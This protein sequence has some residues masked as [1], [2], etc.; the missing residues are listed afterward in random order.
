M[1]TFLI[2]YK[3]PRRIAISKRTGKKGQSRKYILREN[4]RRPKEICEMSYS[5]CLSSTL[6]KLGYVCHI[7]TLCRK[8]IKD[9]PSPSQLHYLC[10]MQ[11]I[12]NANGW[13]M[14]IF[15]QWIG[16]TFSVSALKMLERNAYKTWWILLC[17][18]TGGGGHFKGIL[19]SKHINVNL[20]SSFIWCSHSFQVTG[21]C[22]SVLHYTL[23]TSNIY[24]M[25]MF[26]LKC[27][28]HEQFLCKPCHIT[29]WLCFWICFISSIQFKLIFVCVCVHVQGRWD[30]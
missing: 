8:L 21:M 1:T 13:F 30:F 7:L 14:L 12:M 19:S 16:W 25:C 4:Q 22:D 10:R 27:M 2:E 23:T 15:W 20:C 28:P 24:C 9:S 6:Q 3:S 18:W 5:S 29:F 26:I 11:E 17:W